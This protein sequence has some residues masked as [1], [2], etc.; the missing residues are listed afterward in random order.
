MESDVSQGNGV[1]VFRVAWLGGGD[2]QPPTSHWKR[3]AK[4][5]KKN[6]DL[7]ASEDGMWPTIVYL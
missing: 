7:M 1:A 3:I 4:K 6:G 2:E 5:K